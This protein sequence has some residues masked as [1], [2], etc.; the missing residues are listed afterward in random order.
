M[1]F[2]DV[3]SSLREAFFM[4]WETL[5]ALILGFGISGA[6]QAFV[7]RGEMQRILGR[8]GIGSVGRATFL[9][10]V[11]SSCSYAAT[12]MAK[13]LFQKGADFTAAMVFMFASTNLVIELGIV[14]A[15]L[16]GWQFTASE[17]L[18]GLIMI[19]LFAI[20]ARFLLPKRLVDAARRRLEDGSRDSTG[21]ENYAGSTDH[22]AQRPPLRQRLRSI[23]GWSDAASYT[24][25]DIT[26]L[27]KEMVIGFGV[28]GLLAVLVPE[29]AWS[30]IFLSGHGFW[31]TLENVV[32][33]P[34]IAIIS[35]V[36]SIGNVPLAA[37]LWKGGIS[38]GGVAS[39]IFADLITLP[40]LLIYRKF[41][42]WRLTLWLLGAF[43][44]VMSLAGLIVEYIFVAL[45]GV[46]TD[47]PTEIA[48]TSFQWN[49]TTYLN[50]LFLAVLAVLYY[51][52]RNRVRF[53]GGA[54]YALDLVCGM[55]VETSS[56][57]ARVASH[58]RTYYFC[59]DR[60][61][62]KFATSPQRYLSGA[63][64]A[65]A[66][67]AHHGYSMPAG[68][69]H[70]GSEVDPVCGMSV[71]LESAAAHREQDGVDYWF[72]S[73]GCASAFDGDHERPTE[74]LS[75]SRGGPN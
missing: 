42:G 68:A 61:S 29:S 63:L 34:F 14:L 60:C 62:A 44:L 65:T 70:H 23:A 35:F 31:S 53:G 15:L 21:D 20:L 58:G 22:H 12:A 75:A 1:V 27:R 16:I 54:G 13:S 32:L 51:L 41:Y 30:A 9:G 11:S 4:F 26:M 24:M 3:G 57:P 67:A 48:P 71:D 64:P 49:Y 69:T 40:L 8:P 59:S 45:H 18:G 37:A 74:A 56:A 25:A 17:F 5:W 46:P 43:W 55:Q 73:E 28:A 52:H 39:F 47:R 6:V 72:C 36:C 19:A 7:S 2:T 38:F 50:I 66:D 10:T 33:G